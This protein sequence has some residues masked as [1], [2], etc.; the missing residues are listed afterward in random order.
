MIQL[1]KAFIT[2]LCVESGGLN[3]AKHKTDHVKVSDSIWKEEYF[4]TPC[5]HLLQKQK[6]TYTAFNLF[7]SF[8]GTDSKKVTLSG[9]LGFNDDENVLSEFIIH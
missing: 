4:M 8:S 7:L 1:I 2:S 6:K 3:Q 9:P 5:L